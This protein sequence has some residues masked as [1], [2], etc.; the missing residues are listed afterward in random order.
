MMKP[1]IVTPHARE[2][3]LEMGETE[4]MVCTRFPSSERVMQPISRLIYKQE[5]YGE[6]QDKTEYYYSG[7]V[8]YTV[9]NTRPA[10]I[11]ITVH[12]KKISKKW[13][14]RGSSPE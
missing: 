14:K 4:E 5:K 12:K 2:R 9:S 11:L 10:Y 13:I 1:L 3:I 7:G 6:K 8:M